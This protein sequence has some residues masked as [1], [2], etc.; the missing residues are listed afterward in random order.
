M[1]VT[2]CISARP[3]DALAVKVRTPVDE[4]PISELSAGCS[5]STVMYVAS[6]CFVSISEE[7]VSTMGVCGVIG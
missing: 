7:I 2:S 1:P 6:Y 3:W 5:D 4:A